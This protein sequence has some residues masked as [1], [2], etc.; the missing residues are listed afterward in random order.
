M[1]KATSRKH[2]SHKK[3]RAHH[4]A[5]PHARRMNGAKAAASDVTTSIE[6]KEVEIIDDESSFR[7]EPRISDDEL[8]DEAGIYGA[9]RGETAG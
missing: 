9:N 1:A 2:A 4:A 5:K 7:P 6:V 8:D 3:A